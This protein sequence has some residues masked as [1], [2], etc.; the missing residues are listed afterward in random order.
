[1]VMDLE[2]RYFRRSILGV[3]GMTLCVLWLTKGQGCVIQNGA[4][5]PVA[6]RPQLQPP[7]PKQLQE[8]RPAADRAL[9]AAAAAGRSDRSDRTGGY[10]IEV[11][12]VYGSGEAAPGVDVGVSVLGSRAIQATTTGGAG[13]AVVSVP[14][15]AA[16]HEF[17]VTAA[18]PGGWAGGE[19]ARVGESITLTLVET[20]KMA[21]LVVDST[22]A[23]PVSG[24]RIESLPT[25]H[26][27]DVR[28]VAVM[29]MPEVAI[30]DS[31]GRAEWQVPK[32]Q[33]TVVLR[34]FGYH[35]QVRHDQVGRH[36]TEND[37]AE[38]LTLD[39]LDMGPVEVARVD[40]GRVEDIQCFAHRDKWDSSPMCE[41]G[42]VVGGDG[43]SIVFQVPTKSMS[44][45]GGPG[46]RAVWHSPESIAGGVLRLSDGV[47][48]R[49]KILEWSA[50]GPHSA[51]V[52]MEMVGSPEWSPE[53][54][55]AIDSHGKFE[56]SGLDANRRYRCVVRDFGSEVMRLSFNA[57]DKT[58]DLG[59]LTMPE[60]VVVDV[61]V[62]VE[63]AN[64]GKGIVNA[65]VACGPN[66]SETD[67]SGYAECALPVREDLA[68]VA[69]RHRDY[70]AGSVVVA[71]SELVA[72]SVLTI[73][74]SSKSECVTGEVLDSDGGPVMAA[75]V[76]IVQAYQEGGPFEGSRWMS[77]TSTDGLGG[78]C[79]P[80]AGGTGQL[81][82]VVAPGYQRS[83]VYMNPNASGACDP[84]KV[85]LHRKATLIVTYGPAMYGSH[86]VLEDG[87]RMR[88]STEGACAL[89][90]RP[91]V[92]TY[93]VVGPDGAVVCSGKTQ[94]D[95]G[96]SRKI[97]LAEIEPPR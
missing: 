72:N 79:V 74:L 76:E 89:D 92:L 46:L 35:T 20:V 87:S 70:V 95:P 5:T 64:G 90:V 21:V 60:A 15:Q 75:Q 32:I 36:Q 37:A 67:G 3:L 65:V 49:G 77:R 84:V 73:R 63:D 97:Y 1:M 59:Y 33:H 55:S 25:H 48:A 86:I 34:A 19:I 82:S 2:R 22:T 18:A 43:T 7:Q 17:L 93:K 66:G 88:L 71:T 38:V 31:N 85:T 68:V 62:R 53:R 51:V 58:T 94:V 41:V 52:A 80:R 39:P 16:G 91:G 81:I 11:R 78:F 42:G 26:L 8:P 56:V 24:C 27:A 13:M 44:L 83:R 9:V 23:I 12:V 50:T 57:T 45:F 61:R 40:A 29:R 47:T 28:S 54:V 69:V 96:V 14:V 10:G 6:R 4:N 30:T